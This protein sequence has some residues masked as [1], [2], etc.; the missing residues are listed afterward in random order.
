MWAFLWALLVV[1]RVTNALSQFE[2]DSVWLWK[3]TGAL[4]S[5]ESVGGVLA[6]NLDENGI[7]TT[8]D[9]S[10]GTALHR[11]SYERRDMQ[12][13][14][15]SQ[16]MVA[17]FGGF[18][19]DFWHFRLNDM[20][21]LS[22]TIVSQVSVESDIVNVQ[23]LEEEIY[24]I[25][26]ET[27]TKVDP[28]IGSVTTVSVVPF[29]LKDGRL[30][31][32]LT[33]G[34]L[35]LF[36]QTDDA[37]SIIHLDTENQ[38]IFNGCKLTDMDII[39]SLDVEI[40]CNHDTAYRLNSEMN[41]SF[42]AAKPNM[43]TAATTADS[44]IDEDIE[45]V[46]SVGNNYIVV[47]AGQSIYIINTEVSST[48]YIH[49]FE[50]P[51]AIKSSQ[52]H[53]FV[54]TNNGRTS[55]ILALSDRDVVECY[56]NGIWKWSIDQSLRSIKKAVSI[57]ADKE[58]EAAIAFQEQNILDYITSPFI[59]VASLLSEVQ[60]TNYDGLFGFNK[61]LLALTENGKIGV[62]ELHKNTRSQLVKIID[63]PL[64]ID[65][66]VEIDNNVFLLTADAV[67]ELD[68]DSET[69]KHVALTN[70]QLPLFELKGITHGYTTNISDTH[71][72]GIHY[73]KGESYN[74]WTHEIKGK[75]VSL[76]KRS[77]KNDQVA[78]NVV[79]LPSRDV[80][81]K[82][83]IPNLAVLATACNNYVH[84]DL[85]NIITGQKLAGWIKS[86]DGPV[87]SIHLAFEEN[88]IVLT[89]PYNG[90]VDETE[91]VVIDMFESL[92]P[93]QRFTD[94]DT[95][96]DCFSHIP[97]PAF[98]MQSFILGEKVD[99]LAISTTKN[100]VAQQTVVFQTGG[101]LHMIPKDVI[102]GRRGGIVGDFKNKDDKFVPISRHSFSDIIIHQWKY[103]PALNVSPNLELTQENTILS[104]GKSLL[105]TVPTNLA[106][107]S[108]LVSI[109]ND[110]FVTMIQPSGSFDMLTSNFKSNIVNGTIAILIVLI[111]LFH[112][113]NTQKIRLVI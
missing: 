57:D 109:T 55:F 112:S 46:E 64:P 51:A 28:F 62:F 81:Y 77:Y 72:N 87:E 67:Y 38:S 47:K 31:K 20:H 23:L 71:I 70:S 9:V 94:V 95:T 26:S 89:L 18:S 34:S 14:A 49:K 30:V 59:Y 88:H 4:G 53:S 111:I 108:Y 41:A 32:E 73:S 60:L 99:A 44:F 101:N 84:V 39:V 103:D 113:K 16:G 21:Q 74:T 3:N 68:V 24:L 78:Q 106:S 2:Q 69:V 6:V 104:N 82:Y 66:I 36:G 48:N 40:V 43:I 83:L 17:V 97:L 54:F 86:Y 92:T 93:N 110:I 91:V 19:V 58:D 45:N 61:L 76:L 98:A 85:L 80:L 1:F 105:L 27:I 22:A 12:M 56:R 90:S 63:L 5:T 8:F 11:F 75:L 96:F 79:V 13:R 35:V 50:V 107:T 52:R 42:V 37:V 65:D 15:L 100:N 33:S 10:T 25:Q 29:V 7:L 102:D